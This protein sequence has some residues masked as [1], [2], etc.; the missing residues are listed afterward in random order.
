[1]QKDFSQSDAKI[2]AYAESV[3][4]PQDD[5]LKQ[6]HENMEKNDLPMIQVGT[7]DGLHLEVITRA[8]GAKKASFGRVN[9]SSKTP[10]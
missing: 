1:M 4:S 2:V 3:F 5:I 10:A 8:C 6:A 9:W 7:F